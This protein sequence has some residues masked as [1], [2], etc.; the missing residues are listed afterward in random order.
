MDHEMYPVLY[1]AADSAS[2]GAQRRYLGYIRVNSF[3]LIA[4]TGLGV[5][6][7]NDR[8]SA[9][10]AALLI[11]GAMVVSIFMILTKE[12]EVWY[13]AR[14]VAESVKSLSWK[15]MMKSEPFADDKARAKASGVFRDILKSILAGHQ[16][17]SHALSGQ[18]VAA[19]QISKKMFEVRDS[20]LKE[21]IEFY[22]LN[23][24]ENQLSWYSRKS[25]FNRNQGQLWF[26]VL[27]GTQAI[28]VLFVVLRV[29]YPGFKF[30]PAEL[31]VVAAGSALSW[32]Q[33]RKFRELA[34]A[35]AVTA[36]E[37]GLVR[38]ELDE[39]HDEERFAQFVADSESAFS[40]EHTQWH[41]RKNLG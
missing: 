16:D 10:G 2:V 25:I 19:E 6:G 40:R 23:R 27:L 41:A 3:L 29:A 31:F 28:A 22:K 20:S 30:W 9:I 15:F 5:Y 13:R 34:S 14:A 4:A 39:V 26:S 12:E 8:P 7:I 36:H 18:V 38:S 24:I 21:R 37:I 35:Y 11:I 1:E 33:T 17:I 32:I